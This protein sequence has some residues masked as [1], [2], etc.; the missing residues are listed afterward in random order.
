MA[1]EIMGKKTGEEGAVNHLLL[2]FLKLFLFLL[3]VVFDF[4]LGFGAGVFYAF[5]AVL[6]VRC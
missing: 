4:L 2:E 1:G 6:R 5:G 3:S